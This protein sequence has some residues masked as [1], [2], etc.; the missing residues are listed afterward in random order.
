MKADLP[1]LFSALT[2]VSASF[3]GEFH[4]KQKTGNI[5]T[6]VPS[7]SR[8]GPTGNK[9]VRR[10]SNIQPDSSSA[11]S[12]SHEYDNMPV[13]ST[14][15]GLTRRRTS[16][17]QAERTPL[18]QSSRS[19]GTEFMQSNRVK[20]TPTTPIQNQPKQELKLQ[21]T[22]DK[23][24]YD[25]ASQVNQEEPRSVLIEPVPEKREGEG[26][27]S[28]TTGTGATETAK[29]QPNSLTKG[30]GGSYHSTMTGASERS[31]ARLH[32]HIL[33]ETEQMNTIKVKIAEEGHTVDCEEMT[34]SGDTKNSLEFESQNINTEIT[35][36]KSIQSSKPSSS[37]HLDILEEF[38][39]NFLK[40][41]K[42]I[43]LMNAASKVS[44]GQMLYDRQVLVSLVFGTSF[45]V[46][47][48]FFSFYL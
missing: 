40:N 27:K 21:S 1:L 13:G 3:N 9:P 11:N 6:F 30:S 28:T 39:D 16:A 24:Q 36:D 10:Q 14:M 45:N 25:Q 15:N 33:K 4:E 32:H 2:A 8:L 31:S 42:N 18:L 38:R 12:N 20:S 37:T 17:N 48:C 26:S 43:A 23:V 46:T 5:L 19:Q 29:L 7:R 22:K 44:L 47:D 34:G 35:F 41:P